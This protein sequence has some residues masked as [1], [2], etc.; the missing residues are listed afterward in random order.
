MPV[1]GTIAELK[2]KN[3]ELNRSNEH[4]EALV[5]ERTHELEQAVAEL[6]QLALR[7]GLTGLFNH[8]HFQE[9]MEAEFGRAQ[10]HG[11]PLG[12]LFIDV[13]HFK[14][15]NDQHG[16]PAGDRLLRRKPA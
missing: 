1:A 5:R 10:R 13:D 4:L 16:H 3:D 7:D 15:Y 12:L 2:V 11:H 9:A 14:A 6:K 8:R